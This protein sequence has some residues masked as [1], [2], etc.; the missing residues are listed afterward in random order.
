V[1]LT[2]ARALLKELVSAV[3]A[4]GVLDVD[5]AAGSHLLQVHAGPNRGHGA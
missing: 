1:H 3:V 5:R 2:N 4:L